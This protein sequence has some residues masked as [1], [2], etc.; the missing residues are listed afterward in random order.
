MQHRFDNQYARLFPGLYSEHEPQGF[1]R[2]ELVIANTEL[3]AQ[4][5]LDSSDPRF[6]NWLSG[7]S[8]MPGAEPIAQ[9]YAGH[10][11][12]V[13]NPFLG[14][15]RGLLLGELLDVDQQ[16]WDLHLKGAGPTAYARGGDGRAVLRSCIREFLASEA[17]HHLGIPSTRALAVVAGEVAVQRETV[18]R[19][20]MLT[21]AART[22]I[23]FGHFEHCFHKGLAGELKALADF[24]I[25]TQLPHLREFGNPYKALFQHTVTVTASLIAQWQAQGFAHG[26]MNTDN[27]SMLGDTFD[28]GP[29]GFLDDY[30]P[31]FVCNHSD[32]QGRYA[33]DQQPSIGLWNLNCLAMAF[34]PLVD[35]DDLVDALKGYQGHV[36]T[37]YINLMRRKLGLASHREIDGLLLTELLGLM[38]RE[39]RD[40]H[41]TFR[42]LCQFRLDT[43]PSPVRDHFID[44]EAFDDWAQHYRERLRV[45]DSDDDQRQLAMKAVNPSYVL[46]NYL[47][48]QAIEA[49]EQGDFAPLHELYQVLQRPFEDQPGREAYARTPPDWGKHLEISCSS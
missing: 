14:D 38:A 31:G 17:L 3:A 7:K 5:G 13:Y 46:R 32:H 36:E 44:R 30:E 49:A 43:D 12:G 22:H 9:K 48:Q 45:E 16:R 20:A 8:A 4:L 28:Y 19:G 33:F 26:V 10:Q 23:R 34:S 15:G 11:F 18:E 47:A 24:L 25:D 27:M 35:S 29:Y 37:T 40:Y 21:R 42:A 1:E 6:V 39:K 2:P 41:A